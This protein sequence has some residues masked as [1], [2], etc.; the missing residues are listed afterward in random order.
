MADTI[1]T[2]ALEELAEIRTRREWIQ[3][4]AA[5]VLTAG[6][7]GLALFVLLHERSLEYLILSITYL[8]RETKGGD[9]YRAYLIRLLF[10]RKPEIQQF[11]ATHIRTREDL[12]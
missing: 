10:V 4:G 3:L 8:V 7:Y 11:Q 9:K 2:E 5:L 1:K 6:E 12:Q